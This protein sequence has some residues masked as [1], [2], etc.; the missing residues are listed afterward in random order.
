M[1]YMYWWLWILFCPVPQAVK[2]KHAQYQVSNSFTTES[3][4]SHLSERRRS[5]KR[6]GSLSSR[7]GSKTKRKPKSKESK[8]EM[9]DMSA[10]SV[11]A[12]SKLAAPASGQPSM[13]TQPLDITVSSTRVRRWRVT[14]CLPFS[15]NTTH[16]AQSGSNN[17]DVSVLG[18]YQ[19]ADLLSWQN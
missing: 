12:P 5:S 6:G 9:S 18:H 17:C 11:A 8:L 15:N 3:G 10:A 16:A 7:L 1:I 19:K 14:H 2:N 13:N 4:A